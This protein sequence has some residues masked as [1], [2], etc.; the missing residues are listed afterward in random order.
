ME[1]PVVTVIAGAGADGDVLDPEGTAVDQVQ[2]LQAGGKHVT[3]QVAD[4]QVSQGHTAQPGPQG[5]DYIRTHDV[6]A[7][8]DALTLLA[9]IAREAGHA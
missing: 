4:N 6:A 5:A 9:V 1:Q 3:E 2:G 7:A 8:R